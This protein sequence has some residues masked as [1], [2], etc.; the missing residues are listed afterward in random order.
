MIQ[1]L[2]IKN[3]RGFREFSCDGIGAVTIVGG[4]NNCGKTSFLEAVY[5]LNTGAVA[6]SLA[7]LSGNRRLPVSWEDMALAFSDGDT[8]REI[9]LSGS[10]VDGRTD[11]VARLKDR[12]VQK[13]TGDAQK[14]A[15]LAKVLEVEETNWDKSGQSKTFESKFY[16]VLKADP[17]VPGGFADDGWLLSNARQ[18]K[19]KMVYLSSSVQRDVCIAF[20]RDALDKKQGDPIL[21]AMQ[22]VDPRIR[23]LAVNGQIKVDVEGVGHLLPVQV[24]GD[25]MQK[26]VNVLSSIYFCRGGGCVA[27]DEIDNGL[28]YSAYR[29]LMKAALRFATVH[30]VQLFMTTH[31]LEFLEHLCSDDEMRLLVDG[32]DAFSYL[33]LVRRADSTIDF[34]RYS[35]QQLKE[36]V[37][38]GLEVR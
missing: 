15:M 25:G 6:S 7:D 30:D 27:I 8:A 4:R 18:D 20:L 35:F 1:R 22:S 26:I 2:Q 17:P 29:L 3:F 23:G 28:H 37:E 33:N 24:L 34:V 14:D 5:C 36:S 21:K 9:H 10:S 12:S 11:V 16:Y 13:Y 31:N 32:E 38:N 19:P